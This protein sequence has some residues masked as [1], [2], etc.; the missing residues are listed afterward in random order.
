MPELPEV[1]ICARQ[2]SS[3][4]GGKLIRQVEVRDRKLRLPSDLMGRKV[5][6]ICRRGKF[7]SLRLDDGRRI[8]IHLGMTGW[9]EFTP[10]PR[11][12][13][14]ISTDDGTA[15]FE[16]PRLFGEVRVV[17]AKQEETI[18]AKLGPEPL[19]PGFDLA[20]LQHTRR[21][22]KVAL[23][24]QRLIAGI[25]N[26]YAVEALWHA[27][28]NPKRPANRLNE[29]ELRRLKRSILRVLQK[30]IAYGPEIYEVQTFK[31]YDRKGKP[32]YRC[33]TPIQRI[34]LGGRGTY[35]CPG[36]QR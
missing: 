13:L 1:E 25:G 33:R 26:M 12:R 16:D 35:F 3:R 21:P 9:F 22:V 18:L 10:P 5:T 30:A 24:D 20:C 31:V 17:S 34:V 7:I 29:D 6:E 19:S 8:L 36:C 15:Y 2:L 28:I 11:Y 32:C 4:L 27:H 14:A 23:L